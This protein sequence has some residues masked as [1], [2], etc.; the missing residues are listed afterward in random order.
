LIDWSIERLLE[1][2]GTHLPACRHHHDT[3]NHQ[4]TEQDQRKSLAKQLRDT[5]K[6]MATETETW[7]R[8]LEER[9]KH[10]QRT[11]DRMITEDECDELVLDT[12]AFLDQ[13][14]QSILVSER[15]ERASI[16][17]AAAG[18][19]SYMISRF[20]SEAALSGGVDGGRR[21]GG[22]VGGH[23]RALKSMQHFFLKWNLIHSTLKEWKARLAGQQ[24]DEDEDDEEEE[25][26][27]WG[28]YP[29]GA[30]RRASGMIDKT[31]L[32][33]ALRTLDIEFSD[34]ELDRAFQS[35][36]H[37]RGEGRFRPGG[38]LMGGPGTS[39][40]SVDSHSLGKETLLPGAVE[41][42]KTVSF[43]DVLTALPVWAIIMR[44]PAMEDS[45]LS[46]LQEA[47]DVICE[48]YRLLT[49]HTSG[50]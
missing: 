17:S 25:E 14:D 22:T 1:R 12:H 21:L 19:S 41:A 42:E 13:S 38:I 20:F 16:P 11:T 34:A 5:V 46:Q 15:P 32:G 49:R 24:L 39:T 4:Q 30:S 28:P 10:L 23:S 40:S 45:D 26:R 47:V 31:A 2:P 50:A 35:C 43:E 29:G 3:H 33:N 48:G 36:R 8:N 37:S 18:Q 9:L 7:L 44:A 6:W 27:A